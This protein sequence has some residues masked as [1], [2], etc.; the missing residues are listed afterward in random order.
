VADYQGVRSLSE[1][2][3]GQVYPGQ[4]IALSLALRKQLKNKS[5][6]TLERVSEGE[7][8]S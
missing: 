5:S 8:L 4:H 2:I 6:D 3:W 7:F 1:S